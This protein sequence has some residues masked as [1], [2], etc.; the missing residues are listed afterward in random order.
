MDLLTSLHVVNLLEGMDSPKREAGRCPG[1]NVSL[2]HKAPCNGLFSR[3]ATHSPE[4][5][6]AVEGRCGSNL[7]CRLSSVF[8]V[9]GMLSS[10]ASS[11]QGVSRMG[12]FSTRTQ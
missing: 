6:C 1:G 8:S 9:T 4:C 5:A 12:R 3:I 2:C 7:H 10:V 11:P